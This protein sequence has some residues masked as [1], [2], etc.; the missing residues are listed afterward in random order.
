[1]IYNILGYEYDVKYTNDR[2]KVSEDGEKCSGYIDFE[3]HEISVLREKNEFATLLHEVLHAIVNLLHIDSL[4]EEK[5]K[6]HNDLDR[7]AVALTDFLIRNDLLKYQNST[8]E[9]K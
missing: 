1:M 3:K 7:L 4:N 2:R 6:K 8:E 5:E 9:T